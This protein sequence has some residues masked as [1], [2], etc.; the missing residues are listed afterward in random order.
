MTSLEINSPQPQHFSQFGTKESSCNCSTA[1]DGNLIW[2]I[3][4]DFNVLLG[5]LPF[6]SNQLDSNVKMPSRTLKMLSFIR[7]ESVLLLQNNN[8]Q[9]GE[10]FL[11]KSAINSP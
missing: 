11:W 6:P 10:D 7:R 5:T 2:S 3:R 1:E 8:G 9:L 4:L